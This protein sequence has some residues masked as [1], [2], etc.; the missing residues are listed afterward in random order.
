[1]K[2][3]DIFRVWFER[4]MILDFSEEGDGCLVEMMVKFVWY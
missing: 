2:F 3:Y 1:M 4:K